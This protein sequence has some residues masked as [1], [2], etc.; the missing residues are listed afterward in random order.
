MALLDVPIGL[1]V[2]AAASVDVS[3]THCVRARLKV[4]FGAGVRIEGDFVEDVGEKIAG[5][6]IA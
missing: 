4:G 2:A 5:G 6:R 3:D 1:A